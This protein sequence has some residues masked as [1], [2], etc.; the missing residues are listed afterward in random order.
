MSKVMTVAWREFKA[1]AL[2]KAF[3]IGAVL[4]PAVGIGLAVAMPVLL[5]RKPPP[6]AGTV[7]MVDPGGAIAAATAVEIDPETVRAR[8]EE[9]LDEALEK[10]DSSR[11]PSSFSGDQAIGAT[12]DL[13]RVEIDVELER[14]DDPGALDE[15]KR[16]LREGDLV[17]IITVEG[18]EE[19]V[20]AATGPPSEVTLYVAQTTNQK[21]TSL[22]E[23]TLGRAMNRV[24][25]EAAGLD[26]DQVRRLARKRSPKTVQVGA[27]GK[28]HREDIAAK[29]VKRLIPMAFMMLLWMGAFVGANY[30]LTTTIEE[31][32]NKVMEVLLSAVSPMQLM[33][34]KIIGQALVGLV[35]I[36]MYGGVGFVALGTFAFANLITWTQIVL[37]GLYYVMAYFMVASIMAAIGSAVN[38]LREAQSLMTPAMMLLMIPLLLWLPISDSPNGWLATVTSFIPPLIPFVMVI[39][40]AGTEP[41][42]VWQILLSLGVGYAAMLVMVWAAAKI[43]RVGVLMYG[44]PPSPLELIRWLRYS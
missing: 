36:S 1:T 15:L 6:L 8:I 9:A 18:G 20:P 10:L 41:V 40:I 39:R 13:A 30:L 43:F 21:H 31:K 32:S 14:H 28:E 16:R 29:V 2:T 7:A 25:I 26:V 44:K 3:I 11:M 33:A 35:M 27:E 38:E 5:T 34:G 42:A 23:A 4:A 17:A 19:G 24:R 12:R 37:L 22:L